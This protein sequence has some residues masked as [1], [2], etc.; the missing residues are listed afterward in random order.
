M[1]GRGNLLLQWGRGLGTAERAPRGG[2]EVLLRCF[3]GAAVLGPRRD[4]PRARRRRA[5]PRFHGAAGLGARRARRP[6]QRPLLAMSF[7]GG[8]GFG[9]RRARTVDGRT[10]GG[11]MLQWGRGLG[12]AERGPASRASATRPGSFNGAAV[13]GPRRV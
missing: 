2:L 1:Q 9:P 5:R 6:A 12:T 8:A 13:L 10:I 7:N 3:N 4:W 11:V